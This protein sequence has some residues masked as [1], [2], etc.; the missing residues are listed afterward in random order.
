VA[1]TGKKE[2]YFA[3]FAGNPTELAE[4]AAH[5]WFHRG[6]PTPS[7]Q[8]P[9]G[10]PTRNLRPAQ[11]IHCISNHDQTGNQAFGE[12]LNHLVPAAAYRA[13][14]AILCLTPGTPL[15]FMGQE[16]AASSPFLYFTDHHDELGRMVTAGRQR[17]FKDFV[18]ALDQTNGPPVIPDPQAEATFLQSKLRWEELSEPDHQPSLTL[19]RELLHLRRTSIDLRKRTR[20]NCRAERLGDGVVGLLFQESIH[21]G[22]L[23]LVDLQGGHHWEP[24][25]DPFAH[26]PPGWEWR[27]VFSSNEPRFGGSRS[28]GLDFSPAR[29][30]FD[31]PELLLLKPFRAS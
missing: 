18:E 30:I 5:G 17:E 8:N 10:T 25:A 22:L 19:Y 27:I 15:L 23:A 28:S 31:Q 20:Q 4:T 3:K 26:L 16:W 7:L 29:F 12:R 11:L 6:Q 1:L 21:S 13:A 9:R 2:G 14:S 24:S